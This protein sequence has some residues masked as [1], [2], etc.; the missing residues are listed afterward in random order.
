ML[1]MLPKFE[2][3]PISR[4]FI[5]LPNARRPSRIA[6]VQD[7]QAGLEQDDVGRVLRDV[8][9]RRDRD[10]DVRRVE[11]RR[12]VDAVAQ[13]ADDVAAALERQDDPVLLRGRDAGE[14][15]RLLG[16]RARARRRSCAR[17]RRRRRSRAP[18]EPDLAADVPGDQLV[19]AGQDLHHDPVAAKRRSASATP[20]IG[21]SREGHEADERQLA[22]VAGPSRHGLAGTAA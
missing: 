1:N 5:T 13:E 22:L 21:G 16:H 17:S 18:V 20:S 9:G 8:D 15:G 11:R 7:A 10:A 6:G 12:V 19:V 2:L 3:V 4:Y 14:D